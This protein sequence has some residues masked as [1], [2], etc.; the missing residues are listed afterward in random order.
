M[1][2]LIPTTCN[3]K[4][5]LLELRPVSIPSFPPSGAQ[6]ALLCWGISS[7]TYKAELL[8]RMFT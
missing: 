7:P 2:R 3:N 5:T 8:G 6:V 4:Q 1:V